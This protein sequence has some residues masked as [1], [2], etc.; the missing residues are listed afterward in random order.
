MASPSLPLA[1]PMLNPSF[2]PFRRTLYGAEHEIFREELRAFAQTHVAG[3]LERWER[4]GHVDRAIWRLA[5]DAGYLCMTLPERYGGAARDFRY[6]AI[7]REEMARVGVSGTALGMGLHSDVVA[8]FLWRNG[9]E[10]QKD[11]WLPSM[12]RGEAIGALAMTERAAGSDLKSITTHARRVGDHYVIN[13]SKIFITNGRQADVILLVAKTD[14]AAGAKGVSMI[15]VEGDRPGLRRGEPMEKLSLRCEDTCELFF[16]DLR[17]PASSLIGDEGRG[18]AMLMAELPWERLQIALSAQAAAEAA[19][20]WTLAYVDERQVFGQVLSGYQNTRF[21]L[22]DCATE[23]QLGRLM[24]DRCVEM[25]CAG[26]LD[27]TSAA[28]AKLW[29]TELQGRVIDACLQLH[30]GYG[31][32][33]NQPI[34]RAYAD[35][36]VQRIYAGTNE[37]MREIIA[38]QLWQRR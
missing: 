19:L 5:G 31:V 32:L 6:N 36:R 29:C 12:C 22:A 16:D 11:R 17:V 8:P 1:L 13:G 10:A 4:Q 15:L 24:I 23:V 9:S 34:A 28:M 26:T 21:T 18:F 35:A 7:L 25:A 38:R 37:I 20:E 27:N 3:G 30:G 14:P 33:W 2:L